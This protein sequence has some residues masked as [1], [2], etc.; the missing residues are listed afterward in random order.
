MEAHLLQALM[1][2]HEQGI[3]VTVMPHV[4]ERLT[5]RVPV[6]HVG[7]N[8]HVIMPV[9]RDPNRLYLLTKRAMD[10]GIALLGGVVM[11]VLLP[12][13]ALATALESPGPLFYRQVRVG[14]G[15]R[16]FEVI[17]FRTMV[18]D[19]EAEGPRWATE[20][21]ERITR[22][23]RVLRR[24][25]L[26]ELPQVINV[27]RGDMSI[28]GPR[29]ERPEFVATLEREIPF[30]R[31]RHALRPGVTG[32]A[33]VNYGYGAS[34]EDALVKL[35]YDLYYAK[36]RSILLDLVILVRTVGVVVRLRGR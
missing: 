3:Q 25:R 5:G 29:P 8:F 4:Y 27:L 1:D 11:I 28:I 7:S 24:L 9:D 21:D 31:A 34:T 20:R 16:L 19:A 17:K 22:V 26:D 23:G 12:L 30:Y 13:V 6:E 18:P 15:G 10:L 2:C 33:Q 36:H 35:Q 14:R 32:W